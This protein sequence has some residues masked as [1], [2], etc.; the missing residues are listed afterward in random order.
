[1]SEI[2]EERVLGMTIRRRVL[3][4]RIAGPWANAMAESQP[5]MDAATAALVLQCNDWFAAKMY[6]AG[7]MT[8]EEAKMF[9]VQ[10]DENRP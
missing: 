10:P 3:P 4:Y 6:D 2:I 1:M 5:V 7:W 9:G 8:A